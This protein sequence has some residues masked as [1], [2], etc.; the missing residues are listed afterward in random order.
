[1]DSRRCL[2]GG[3]VHHPPGPPPS[4]PS[5]PAAAVALALGLAV[6]LAAAAPTAGRAATGAFVAPRLAP[7]ASRTPTAPWLPPGLPALPAG[8]SQAPGRRP[9]VA[10]PGAVPPHTMPESITFNLL[11]SLF[12]PFVAGAA[13]LSRRFGMVTPQGP[14]HVAL[15]AADGMAMAAT[16]GEQLDVVVDGPPELPAEFESSFLK[17]LSQRGF[18]H[19]LTDAAGL[20]KKLQEGPVVAYLGFDATADSLHVGSL[21]QI[22]ILRHFQKCGHKPIVLI[23]GGTSKVGDPSGKDASRQ[24]LSEES[25]AQNMAGISRVFHQFLDFGD[26]PTGAVM[27]NNDDWLAQL[28]Y[29]D[30]LRDYGTLFTINR[31]LNFESVK[32]RLERESPLTFLEFNYMLLQAYDFVELNKRLGVTLQM[33]G[34]D[35]WGNIVN[36]VELGRKAAG[37]QLFGLTAPLMTTSDG[38]KMGKT[39][40]GAVWLNADKLSPFDYWQFWRNTADADVIRFLK[41]FTELP[42]AHIAELSAL[43]G[44][45]L[46]DAKRALADEATRLLHGDG[47]LAEI[48]RAVAAQFGG[49]GGG[50]LEGLPRVEVPPERVAAGIPVAELYV[51]C[52]FTKT[53]SEARR[54]IEGGGARLNDSPIRDVNLAL[55]PADFAEG[56]LK[57]SS[58][59]KKHVVVQI[60][61]GAAETS[62]VALMTVTGSKDNAAS[63]AIS[64]N[65]GSFYVTTPIYYVNDVPHIGHAY[66]TVACDCFARH[67]RLEGVPNVR[68]VTGTDEHGQKVQASAQRNEMEPHAYVDMRSERFRELAQALN[69]SHDDFIRTTEERHR[70]AATKLWNRLVAA[71]EIY[72]GR[73][74][75]WYSVRDEAF[76]AESELVDGKAPTGADVQWVVEASYFFRLSQWQQRLLDWFDANPDCVLPLSRRNEVL[77]FVRGGLQD[78][79]VSRTSFAWGLPVPDDPQHVMYVW[80]DALANYLTAAGYAQG[81][82]LD[83]PEGY[84]DSPEFAKV[85][86]CDLHVVGKDI[87][88]FHAV[89]WPCF[90]MAAGLAPP[91]RVFAH[92]WWTKDGQKISKSL[93][94]VVEPF[95]LLARYGV[96]ATRFFLAAEVAF[97][98]DGDFSE[99]RFRVRVNTQLCNGL[100]NLCSRTLGLIYKN[101]DRAIPALEQPFAA[102]DEELL[103]AARALPAAVRAHMRQQVLHKAVEEVFAVCDLANKYIEV[104]AP[105]TLKKTDFGR[106]KTVLYVVVETIR[107]MAIVLSPV[108]PALC[109][110]I[111]DSLGVLPGEEYRNVAALDPTKGP[112]RQGQTIPEPKPLVPRIL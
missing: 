41:I 64:S 79:S 109:A 22:M 103:A 59:K 102:A 20:D 73:Y 45:A 46:N 31:M 10:T 39:A 96:D 47:C 30:F 77:Q 43:E 29:L 74:E 32:Q 52:G 78:L 76:F 40:G 18:L 75:G 4:R 55:G 88:R 27:V 94:N 25:I 9:P 92:G 67:A 49:G 2:L 80:V 38:R 85:W 6:L 37:V 66:T 53:R 86:P 7:A 71:G 33:G 60:A 107:H 26:G 68:F 16:N 44:A 69:A 70:R 34:S 98:A 23:G 101:C 48:H 72:Q 82:A 61:P 108:T 42:M 62:D 15:C 54:L 21:L 84:A 87:L 13:M 91:K 5:G 51:A 100:G 83:G 99:E 89:Y 50:S 28:K 104:Q 12:V 57:L 24:L 93:G 90:L 17:T 65:E 81:D 1:M 14:V 56:R 35:Q 112:L 3:A 11:I 36:G 95:D 97:G 111:L 19:Q 106:M 8:L 110:A 63:S 105:W 58:G